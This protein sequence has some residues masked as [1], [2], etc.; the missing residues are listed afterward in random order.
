[1]RKQKVLYKSKRQGINVLTML[2]ETFNECIYFE[3]VRKIF[4]KHVLLLN[5]FCIVVC[6]YFFEKLEIE[7]H[8]II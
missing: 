8:L 7:Y 5:V 3:Y 1:M 4:F 6:T 2:S